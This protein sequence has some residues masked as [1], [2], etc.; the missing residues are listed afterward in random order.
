MA[1]GGEQKVPRPE[2]VESSTASEWS[3]IDDPVS[4]FTYDSLARIRGLSPE[5]S[6]IHVPGL[7]RAAVLA[8]VTSGVCGAYGENGPSFVFVKRPK[9]ASTHAGEIAFPGGMAEPEDANLEATALREAH[10]EIALAPGRVDVLAELGPEAV[11]VTRSIVTPF[12]GWVDELPEL[13]PE[14]GEVDRILVVPFSELLD[15]DTY[16]SEIWF[17]GGLERRMHFFDIEGE[18]IWG[19]TAR[20]VHVIFTA[21]IG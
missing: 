2:P 21:V 18:T 7:R 13:I 11:I 20:M 6:A 10:E 5:G 9:T 3:G 8:L 4:L 19:L 12:L 15:P 14:P 16:H 1:R 17:I